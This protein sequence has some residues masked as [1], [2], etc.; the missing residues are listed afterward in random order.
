MIEAYKIYKLWGADA[1][2]SHMEEKYGHLLKRTEYREVAAKTTAAVEYLD[3]MSIVTASGAVSKEAQLPNLLRQIMK[4][5]T[6]NSGAQRACMLLKSEHG[7][8]I[9]A[10]RL[11][12][13]EETEVLQAIPLEEGAGLLPSSVINFCIHTVDFVVPWRCSK[14]RTL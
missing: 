4:T 6:E 5:V 10:E 12:G 14:F 9:E 3:M 8:R 7:W 2:V 13:V 1:K 11:P